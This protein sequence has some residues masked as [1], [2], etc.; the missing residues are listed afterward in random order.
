[1]SNDTFE[2]SMRSY[3]E[4]LSRSIAHNRK[5]VFD[6]LKTAGITSVV[7]DFDGVGDSGDVAVRQLSQ[8]GPEALSDRPVQIV[9]AAYDGSLSTEEM[10]LRQALQSLCCDL[11]ALHHPG[12]EINEGSTGE[13]TFDVLTETVHLS[14]GYRC[15]D[16][17]YI[18]HDL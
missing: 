14:F 18:E 13:F 4:C 2:P 17:E 8:G 16:V 9:D 3:D 7:V 6:A 10:P 11:L 15:T 5:A 1:M 12:W